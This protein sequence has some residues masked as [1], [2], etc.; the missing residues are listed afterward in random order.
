MT[1]N[2]K[3]LVVLGKLNNA[4]L[5]TLGKN[6][7]TLD[8]PASAYPMMAHLNEVGRART[9]KLGE[10]AIITSGSI[11]HMV[12]KLIKQGYV[13]KVQ[14]EEDKRVFWIQITELG[15]EAFMKVRKEHTKYLDK[16]LSDITDE[17]KEIFIDQIKH[18]GKTI[19]KKKELT[20]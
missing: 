18:F 5:D 10:V 7:N 16:L 13:A 19:E 8:M 12:N 9:Q 17:E 14:D 2:V 20:E 1:N 11:T 6:L 15:R 3:L 4:L